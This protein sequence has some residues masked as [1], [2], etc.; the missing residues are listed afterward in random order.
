M[1]KLPNN[2]KQLPEKGSERR[3]QKRTIFQFFGVALAIAVFSAGSY[4]LG[5]S[6]GGNSTTGVLPQS[7]GGTGVTDLTSLLNAKL[8]TNSIVNSFNGGTTVPLSAEQGKV[9]DTRTAYASEQVPISFATGAVYYHKVGRQVSINFKVTTSSNWT[10]DGPLGQIP[11]GYYPT[12]QSAFIPIINANSAALEGK[13]ALGVLEINTSGLM[14]YHGYGD[15]LS[16]TTFYGSGAWA[17]S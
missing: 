12:D 11:A 7:K 17:T 2:S 15:L 4:L 3:L 9:L 8:N 10:N 16:S 1:R 13:Q 6:Q 14:S 5:L